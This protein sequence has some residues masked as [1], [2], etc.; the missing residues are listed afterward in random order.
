MK[1]I[2]YSL[3][4]TNPIYLDGAV[5]N[6]ADAVK[7]YPDYVARFYV[8]ESVKKSVVDKLKEN[9]ARIVIKKSDPEKFGYYW[10]F[11]P[12]CGGVCERVLIRDTDSLM[13]ERESYA[14]LEWEES[15]LP[16]HIMRDDWAHEHEIVGGAC[17][18]VCGSIPEFGKLLVDWLE[19]LEPLEMEMRKGKPY[20]YTDE[21]FLCEKIWP[22]V[23]DKHLAHDEYFNIS[24]NKRPFPIPGPTVCNKRILQE[25]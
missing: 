21:I 10:R 12:I 18:F 14:V 15:G 9:G 25:R 24:E 3:F 6:S 19:N 7:F 11:D 17:G 20:Y 13:S 4:G 1:L 16:V 5:Q 23:K 22:L 2:S 8:H